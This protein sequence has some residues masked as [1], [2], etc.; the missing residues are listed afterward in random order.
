MQSK[1][2]RTAATH[3]PSSVQGRDSTLLQNKNIRFYEQTMPTNQQ[4]VQ[5]QNLPPKA[6]TSRTS[7]QPQRLP[8]H[9]HRKST[10][11]DNQMTTAPKGPKTLNIKRESEDCK[12]AIEELQHLFYNQ[13][14]RAQSQSSSRSPNRSNLRTL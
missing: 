1:I 7:L 9:T 12:R 14:S 5:K 10:S 8:P 2:T 11:P 6:K 3:R 13:Q 4:R